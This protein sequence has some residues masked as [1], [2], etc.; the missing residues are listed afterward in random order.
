MKKVLI[1]LAA[2]VVLAVMVVMSTF[3]SYNSL[4][5]MDEE[6]NR[7]WAVVESS[8]QRRFDL[9]PNLVET[10]KGAMAHEEEVFTAIADARARLAGAASVD[11]SVQASNELEGALSRLL[12]VVENYPEL[13]SNQ[14]VTGLMDELAGT[15]NRINTER[16][17]YNDA[18]S[19][20]NSAI[21]SFPKNIMATMF[22]FEKR[23]Y[24][25]A[26]PGADTA[27]KVNFD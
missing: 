13:K 11:E 18:V 2:L 27:P 20:Y 3:G 22:G 6:V 21:R 7:Q 14:N 15:E 9:I 8:L 17:R 26:S 19:K 5:A 24:F 16:N 4:V 10:V 1:I 23:P 12:V 25:E